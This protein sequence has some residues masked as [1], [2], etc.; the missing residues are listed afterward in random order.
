MLQLCTCTCIPALCLSAYAFL[1]NLLGIYLQ[2]HVDP[3]C[4]DLI[5]THTHTHSILQEGLFSDGG[6]AAEIE[7]IMDMLDTGGR[8]LPGSTYSVASALLTFLAAL[9]DPVVPFAL[10]QRCM[11]CYN[12]TTLQT[13]TYIVVVV[14]I[15]SVLLSLWY[16]HRL[17]YMY[18]MFGYV[19][20]LIPFLS[21]TGFN[22]AINSLKLNFTHYCLYILN[23]ENK[24]HARWTILYKLLCCASN[25]YCVCIITNNYRY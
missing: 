12:N 16:T 19:L 7:E 15:K 5:G 10:H 1:T 3:T 2:L 14:E 8:E 18:S 6:R 17:L 20:L 21:V 22:M 25:N 11:D 9:A 4:N 13:G 23:P 24:A